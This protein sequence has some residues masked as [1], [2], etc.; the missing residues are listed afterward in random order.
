[1]RRTLKLRVVVG[2]A[3]FGEALGDAGDQGLGVDL[4]ADHQIDGL[5]AAGEHRVERLGLGH[6]AGEAVEDE[7]WGALVCGPARPRSAR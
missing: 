4:Q 5:A 6:G 2:A 3:L 1:M 7:A